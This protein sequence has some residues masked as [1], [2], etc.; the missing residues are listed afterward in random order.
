MSRSVEVLGGL[1]RPLLMLL[2]GGEPVAMEVLA[3]ATGRPLAEVR[4]ALASLPDSELDDRGRVVGYGL[5]LRPTPH[6]FTVDGRL[7]YTWCALDTLVFPAVLGRAATV[8]SPCRATGSPVRVALGLE[9]ITSVEP[10]TAVVSLVTPERPES[11]R[12]AFCNR[13]HFFASADAAAGWL[14][15]NTGAS[16]HPVAEARE[17]AQPLVEAVLTGKPGSL[18][19]SD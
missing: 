12:S 11:V 13:V 16:V 9:R 6:R 15:Q 10:S 18:T 3:D 7:L 19:L 14:G 8:E 4:R 2:A 5:T 17:L 1:Y